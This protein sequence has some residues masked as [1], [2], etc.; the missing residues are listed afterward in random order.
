MTM[1][2]VGRG[3]AFRACL[4]FANNPDGQYTRTGLAEELEAKLAWIE[5]SLKEAISNEWIE[6]VEGTRGADT[7]YRPGRSM[8]DFLGIRS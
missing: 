8:L 5:P 7:L 1:P 3:L 6:R 2:R 4:L